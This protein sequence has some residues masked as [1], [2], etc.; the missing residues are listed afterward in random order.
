MRSAATKQKGKGKGKGKEEEFNFQAPCSPAKDSTGKRKGRPDDIEE[1][2]K[3]KRNAGS[4]QEEAEK[5]E[6]EEEDETPEI[7]EP[8]PPAPPP[9]RE[10]KPP[11]VYSY[12]MMECPRKDCSKQYKEEEGLK[13]HLSH[14]HP[15]YI[16]SNGQIKDAATVEREQEERKK[17]ARARRE[18]KAEGTPQAKA[19]KLEQ[20]LSGSSSRPSSRPSS[21]TP[22]RLPGQLPAGLIAKLKVSEG[23]TSSSASSPQ[24]EELRRED[25]EESSSGPAS[26]LASQEKPPASSPAYSDISDDGEDSRGSKEL[27]LISKPAN[28]LPPPS[29]SPGPPRSIPRVSTPSPFPRASTPSTYSTPSAPTRPTSRPSPSLI[30][31]SCGPN[32]GTP[33]YHKYLAANGF[34]PFPYPYPVGMD[35]NYHVQLLKTDH[36][37]KMKWEKDRAEREKAFKEQLDRDQGKFSGMSLIKEEKMLAGSRKE[38]TAEDARKREPSGGSRTSTPSLISVKAE[39]RDKEPVG[40]KSEVKIEEQGVKPT[41]ETRGPPPGPQTFGYIHPSMMRPGLPPYS[42]SPGLIPPPH[43]DPMMASAMMGG[44]PYGLPPYLSPLAVGPRPPGFPPAGYD[45]LRSPYALPSPEELARAGL[46]APPGAISGTKALDLLQQHASQYYANQKLAELQE[47]ALKSPSSSQ[48]STASLASPT[49][50]ASKPVTTLAG[51]ASPTPTTALG[52]DK[53]KSPPPL[54]HVHTHTHTHIGLG[55]PLMPP[56]AG[57]LPAVAP[58]PPGGLPPPTVGVPSIPPGGPFPG[59]SPYPGKS[60]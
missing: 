14:S 12:T 31:P 15:E 44:S 2:K 37:Y 4:D 51:N 48:A 55:Y 36:V 32:P 30:S 10:P 53:G 34:P 41:M 6:P 58:L 50:M 39:F 8:P 54:R 20:K 47:R 7:S 25:T 16:D 18:A 57:S 9:R 21:S 40:V 49:L 27:P 22:S 42:M 5:T 43:F 26:P 52:G 17:R 19:S 56:V 24:L 23:S 3:R 33:E 1:A 35:P 46:S 29:A 60:P 13:W 59:G 11:L 28:I 45:P 38:K